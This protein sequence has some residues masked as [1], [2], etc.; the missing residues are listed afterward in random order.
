MSFSKKIVS[1]LLFQLGTLLIYVKFLDGPY[2]DW[3]LVYI[4]CFA[5]SLIGILQCLYFFVIQVIKSDFK[6]PSFDIRSIFK[7]TISILLTL[8]QFAFI[9]FFFCMGLFVHEMKGGSFYS[10]F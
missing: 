4:L 6:D 8:S 3:H 2:V 5:F 1:L 9:I 7:I 10:N